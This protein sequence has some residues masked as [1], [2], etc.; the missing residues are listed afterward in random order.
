MASALPEVTLSQTRLDTWKSIAQHLGRSP[1][2][3]QRW[4][5]AYGLPVYHLSGEAGSVY[6]YANDLDHWLKSRG[7]E[8]YQ[9]GCSGQG[10]E[11]SHLN[12][13]EDKPVDCRDF[14]D[15]TL[16]PDETRGRS[17]QLVLLAGK[18]WETFSHRNLPSILN[19]Y[20]DAIDLDSGNAAAYAG[21]SMG[22]LA[23][24]VWG[25][26]NPAAV[27]PAAKAA[28]NNA[29]RIN[30]E[31]PLA[32][33]A[34]AWL[35]M[36]SM[37]DW[38]DA[39]LGFDGIFDQAPCRA[40]IL[41]GRGLLSIA[42]GRLEE[43]SG[44][45]LEAALENPLSSASMAL[46]CWSEYLAGEF[47]Y[48][49]GR[50][51]EIRTT[52]RPGPIID[53]VEALSVVQSGDGA[54]AISRVAALA[55]DSPRHE[56]L[57]G[58]LGYAY[59]VQGQVQKARELLGSTSHGTSARIAHEPYATALILVGL[60]ELEQAT[61]CLEQSYRNGS[62]WSLGF[63]A[64]PILEPLRNHP[65]FAGQI[66]RVRFPEPEEVHTARS[67]AEQAGERDGDSN[68]AAL[69]RPSESGRGPGTE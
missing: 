10:L 69:E 3:V 31:L 30:P 19:H 57:Q 56:V 32:R 12:F 49:L 29:A 43:A 20:R 65:G 27:Y 15:P 53:A 18:L 66:G 35:K 51:E 44:L 28:L 52:G 64:D 17:T 46:H 50:I 54:A 8:G 2:T 42:E 48:G 40:R 7:R 22:L 11:P 37:R 39:R 6:A 25:L 14:G 60:K 41:D 47:E 26:A 21:L 61:D 36:L 45:F 13:S 24:G 16:I 59:A 63:S 38:P 68:S 62:L 67:A 58:V 9:S 23:Q 5:S 34:D 1:R 4:H 55:A 33:C